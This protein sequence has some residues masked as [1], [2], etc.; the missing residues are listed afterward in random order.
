MASDFLFE[1]LTGQMSTRESR[2][3]VGKGTYNSRLRPPPARSTTPHG[4]EA[5]LLLL[6]TVGDGP[7]LLS[8]PATWRTV[9]PPEA[10]GSLHVDGTRRPAKCFSLRC[11]PWSF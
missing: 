10:I 8:P 7:E 9:P 6:P 3:Q 1:S 5:Q 2:G 4:I 11:P